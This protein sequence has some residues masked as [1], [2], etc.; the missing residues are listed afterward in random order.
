MRIETERLVLRRFRPE[1]VEPLAAMGTDPGVAPWLGWRTRDDALAT[2]ERYERNWERFGFGRFA[3]EDRATGAFVGRVGVM[4]QK[5]WTATPEKEEIG[6][7]IVGARQGEGLATEAA[8]AAIADAFDR[9]GL[10]RL[11]SWTAPENVASRRVMEKCGLVY[12]GVTR[13]QGADHVWYAIDA[14][15]RPDATPTGQAA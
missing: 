14:P 7:A 12:Q 15:A 6:W 10:R 8:L 5:R 9:V 13:W 2:I 11:T 1:D 4:H 3:I